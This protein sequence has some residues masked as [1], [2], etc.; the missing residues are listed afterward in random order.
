MKGVVWPKNPRQHQDSNNIE[1]QVKVQSVSEAFWKYLCILEI[2]YAVSEENT[3]LW[4]GML[5]L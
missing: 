5:Q 3:T 1:K 2:F 4:V